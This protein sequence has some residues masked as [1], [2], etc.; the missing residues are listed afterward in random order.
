[1]GSDSRIPLRMLAPAALVLF[2]VLLLVVILSS[3]GGGG[4]GTSESSAT[5][6]SRQSQ[7]RSESAEEGGTRTTERRVYVVRS[8]DTF[9]SIAERTGVPVDQL[10]A[11]NPS[12]D[13]QGLVRGQ[14][15]K[16]RE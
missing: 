7:A 13:P 4:S 12:L 5:S 11:L 16:L 8:G 1:M 9:G 3:V 10:I 15:I 6:G 2:A 14:R